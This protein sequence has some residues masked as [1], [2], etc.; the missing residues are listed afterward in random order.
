MIIVGLNHGEINSSAVILKDGKLIA[1]APEERFNR[2][3]RTNSFPQKA[4]EF[5]L[6][7]AGVDL[8]ECD[9]I[10][11]AWNPGA[12][13][14]KYNSLISKNRV[15]RE[16]YF[17]SL[18]DNLY[19]ISNRTPKDWTKMSFPKDA[20]LPPI[21][22]VQHHRTHTAN[23][24]FLS[25]FEEAAILTSDWRGEFESTTFAHGRGTSFE[26]LGT[27]SIPHSLGMFYATFTEVLGYR[28][29]DDEWKVMALSA[30]DVNCNNHLKK[31]RSTYRLLDNGF[32]ELDQSFYKGAI[33]DQPNLYAPRMIELLGGRPGKK[34]DELN[35]W[36]LSLARA[37]QLAA[38]EIATHM[39]THLHKRTKCDNVALSGGFFMNCVYN[40]KVLDQTPFKNLYVSYAPA[41]VGNSIGAA[42]YVAHVIHD[43]KRVYSFNS[44]YIGPDYADK[45]IENALNRRRIKFKIM[46]LPAR[47]VA[48]L[49]SKGEIVAHFDGKMEFGERA[50]GN[51]S[52]IADPRPKDM[53]DRINSMIKYRESYR[54]F[55]PAVLHEKVHEI[56]DVE[57]DYDC[58]FMEKVALVRPKFREPLA[59]VTHVDGSGRLQT[60]NREH[61]SKF[62]AIISEFEKLAGYPVVLN[63]S[64]NINGEP[65]VMT[66]DD[67]I[68]TF[69]NSGLTNL[70]LG[71][72]LITK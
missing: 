6:S 60:V 14:Q 11:Q 39:L 26:M 23:A 18:P 71:K 35:E 72:Y 31:I 12:N 51:R 5:C 61:N 43:E 65:I 8:A 49:L 28:P 70:V 54:P 34:G 3:K 13:W 15:R 40:G 4:L 19:R 52:I 66:P 10:A 42:L 59:A 63:T 45:D 24:F 55:A 21:Y 9:F 47:E 29:D 25:P 41:D 16:D 46:E 58:H 32:F 48:T 1:G 2:I 33:L 50:L 20:N 44:S 37:M 62:H 69:F 68:S 36:S 64:F 57:P 30:F 22:F 56:F 7:Q 27:Q 17:Y 53:K 38:E 67:A